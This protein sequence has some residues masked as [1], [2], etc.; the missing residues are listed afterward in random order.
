MQEMFDRLFRNSKKTSAT[1]ATPEDVKGVSQ[2]PSSGAPETGVAKQ[3]SAQ[4]P[5][6]EVAKEILQ[7]TQRF[8]YADQWK[9]NLNDESLHS[10]QLFYLDK[11][12]SK[13]I[14]W[15]LYELGDLLTYSLRE[16]RV[17]DQGN[18]YIICADEMT[19][20][21]VLERASAFDRKKH[22]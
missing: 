21:E 5:I 11:E 7:D 3:E 22:R 10:E 15:Y 13:E 6:P 2:A 8:R 12:P 4:P 9:K 1:S 14:A 20:G 17:D 16:E 18:P 19:D